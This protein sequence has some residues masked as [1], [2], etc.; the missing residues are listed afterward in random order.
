[1]DE[2]DP[3]NGNTLTL[4]TCN[5]YDALDDLTQVSQG[6][7]Q[8]RTFAFDSLGRETSETTPE[9]GTTSWTSTAG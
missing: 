5:T 4:T 1:M 6:S 3:G 7:S 8:T 2:P 9:A